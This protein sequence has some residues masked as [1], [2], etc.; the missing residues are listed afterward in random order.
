MSLPSPQFSTP[1]DIHSVGK[2]ESALQSFPAYRWKLALVA[3]FAAV[4][5]FL[6]SV[7]IDWL[8]LHEHEPRRVALEASDCV[9]G[10]IAGSLVFRVLQYEQD[11]RRQ[12]RHRLE[13]IAEMNHHVRNALQVI[14]FSAYSY[15]DQQQLAAVKESV[16]R[17]QWALK[18]ILPKV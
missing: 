16:G 17:I 3:L 15:A 12:L 11:R 6:I 2:N 10:V 8:V 9:A 5:V 4:A 18:E 7:G 13:V 1:P 14:S